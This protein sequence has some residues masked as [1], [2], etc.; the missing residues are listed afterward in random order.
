VARW[1]RN[2]AAAWPERLREFSPWDWSSAEVE[3]AAQAYTARHAAVN[4]LAEPLPPES[5][6]RHMEPAFAYTHF[7]L[8]W[9]RENGREQDLVNEMIRNRLRRSRRTLEG[10]ES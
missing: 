6:E 8:R 10:D 5:W 3:E 2:T 4:G 7:R 1:R 9:A